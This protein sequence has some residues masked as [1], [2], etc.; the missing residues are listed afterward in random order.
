MLIVIAN[1]CEPTYIFTAFC[2]AFGFFDPNMG[3]CAL[4]QKIYI[5]FLTLHLEGLNVP[6]MTVGCILVIRMVF[7]AEI[8]CNSG[9]TRCISYCFGWKS[10]AQFARPWPRPRPP[11]WM[12]QQAGGLSATPDVEMPNSAQPSHL[13]KHV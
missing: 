3:G 10:K 8:C 11:A 1:A 5:G 7:L 4:T 12:W 2:I 9:F 6:S 13:Q